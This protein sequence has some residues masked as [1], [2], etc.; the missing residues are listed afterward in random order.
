M[1]SK[2]PVSYISGGINV[3]SQG[4]KQLEINDE[5]LALSLIMSKQKDFISWEDILS[6]EVVHEV[7]KKNI[8]MGKAIGGGILLGPVGAVLG[9][10]SGS[11]KTSISVLISYLTP[12]KEEKVL[13]LTANNNVAN[14]LKSDIDKELS[15]RFGTSNRKSNK[16]T[17]ELG[18]TNRIDALAKLAE[19]KKDGILSAEEFAEEKK[20]ILSS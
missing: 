15:N 4:A 8:S 1:K 2:Y 11:K 18:I 12:S 6:I 14:K 17:V 20:K 5:G 16:A 7:E 13:T 10:V 3:Y 19:L 9:G